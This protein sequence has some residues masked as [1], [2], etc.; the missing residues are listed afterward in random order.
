MAESR[1][2]QGPF[3][4][5]WGPQEF[6]LVLSLSGVQL[7]GGSNPTGGTGEEGG[8]P[9]SGL[10]GP[11]SHPKTKPSPFSGKKTWAL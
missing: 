4:T 3:L 7:T 9:S 1:I 5:L 10:E 11:P 2:P 6:T 8:P